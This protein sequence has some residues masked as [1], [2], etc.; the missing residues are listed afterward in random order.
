MPGVLAQDLVDRPEGFQGAERDIEE[1]P[2]GGAHHMEGTDSHGEEEYTCVMKLT[3]ARVE[4]V[5]VF[6]IGGKVG[7]ENSRVLDREVR[8]AIEDGTRYLVFD[9]DLVQFLSSGAIGVLVY[10]LRKLQGD[11]GDI[12]VVT[13]NSYVLY[14]FKTIGFH[15]VFEGKIFQSMEGINECLQGRGANLTSESALPWREIEG[16]NDDDDEQSHREELG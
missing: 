6:R 15:R 16:F 7:W 10:H 11:M 2:D 13:S 14:L 9:L 1:V 3:I 5:A 8:Q 12:L 4:S